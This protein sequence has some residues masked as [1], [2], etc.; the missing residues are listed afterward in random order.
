[1]TPYTI[2]QLF[3]ALFDR[4]MDG[5][6]RRRFHGIRY[7]T[8]FDTGGTAQGLALFDDGGEKQWKTLT[9]QPIDDELLRSISGTLPVAP[10]AS[11]DELDVED[12]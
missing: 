10:P 8:R 9:C 4:V 11:I 5:R 12:F 2:P 3:T 6:R 7:R 1:M